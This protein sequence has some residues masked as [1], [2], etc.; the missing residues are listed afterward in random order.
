MGIAMDDHTPVEV[1]RGRPSPGV[2][3]R[4]RHDAFGTWVAQAFPQVRDQLAEG[5]LLCW[6]GP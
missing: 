6:R 3:Q 4:L 1:E 2:L 5:A